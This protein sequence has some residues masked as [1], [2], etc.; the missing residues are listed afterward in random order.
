M[1]KEKIMMLEKNE[2]SF[3]SLWCDVENIGGALV[4]SNRSFAEDPLFNHAVDVGASERVIEDV[5]MYYASRETRP[6]IYV[7]PLSEPGM[8]TCLVNHGFHVF[9]WLDVALR[10]LE[11]VSETRSNLRE[12]KSHEG[13][14]RWIEIYELAFEIPSSWHDEIARRTID[15]LGRDDVA[16]FLMLVAGRPVGALM[17]HFTGDLCGIYCVSV[18]PELRGRGIG[19][20][21]L[22][23]TLATY[24]SYG[25]R[26]ACLQTLRGDKLTH[27]YE[28]LG[29]QI[30]YSKSIYIRPLNTFTELRNSRR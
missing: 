4:F 11:S 29:F 2:N 28:N 12:V 20:E 22:K 26:W 30:L 18:L 6:A 9:D 10:S 13:L 27:F 5:A 16:M 24:S 7:S 1:D 14:S 17:T 3:F 25:Y 19:T 23:E 8:D 15:M 21:M